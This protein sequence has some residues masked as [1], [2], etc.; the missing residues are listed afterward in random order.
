M[1]SLLENMARERFWNF[2]LAVMPNPDII[3]AEVLLTGYGKVIAYVDPDAQAALSNLGFSVPEQKQMVRGVVEHAYGHLNICPGR[4]IRSRFSI[5]EA[6]ASVIENKMGSNL[7]KE[8]EATIQF[9][10]D[11]V[12]DVIVDT[13]IAKE[14]REG[15]YADAALIYYKNKFLTMA[16][17]SMA[18]HFFIRLSLDLFGKTSEHYHDL[19][20]LLKAAKPAGQYP[21]LENM[22]EEAKSFIE[23][24]G[25]KSDLVSVFRLPYQWAK[26]ARKITELFFDVQP[27]QKGGKTEEC[28]KSAGPEDYTKGRIAKG[29]CITP[30]VFG[31]ILTL[32]YA[33]RAEE[34]S[35]SF[36][37]GNAATDKHP[38]SP[39]I[40]REV[41]PMRMP[42]L[43]DFNWPRTLL[44]PGRDVEHESKFQFY[45]NDKYVA[46]PIHTTSSHSIMP[47]ISF[48]VDSSQS[49]E[50]GPFNRRGAYDLLLRTVFGVFRWLMNKGYAEYLHYSVVNFSDSTLYSGWKP[51]QER[52]IVYQTLF[53]YQG[54]KTELDLGVLDRLI[55]ETSRPFTVIMV[56]DGELNNAKALANRVIKRFGVSKNFVLMQI[57]KASKL[58][59]AL[60]KENI[61]VYVIR[62][63]VDLERLVLEGVM[64][65]YK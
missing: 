41:D 9:F 23:T 46:V 55:K 62:Q 5:I 20:K 51:W 30:A 25:D 36:S 47:D 2:E 45:C 18:H 40:V 58:S 31:N 37:F 19:L 63:A 34:V 42:S 26:L 4:D 6:I 60:T 10:A 35:L 53:D 1:F 21:K 65:R 22:L 33:A 14:D 32:W 13:V 24:M 49:M 8:K 48:W 52:R 57:G 11:L 50:F 59:R 28:E 61:P 12:A 43:K 3:D 15:W 64:Q 39:L 54:G 38:V 56:T 44:F 29:G 16:S 7:V 27:A 17:M